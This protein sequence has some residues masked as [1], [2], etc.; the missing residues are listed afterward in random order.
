MGETSKAGVER[1]RVGFEDIGCAAGQLPR[2]LEASIMMV[3]RGHQ[4]PETTRPTFQM[5]KLRLRGQ[6]ACLWSHSK[7]VARTQVL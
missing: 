7:L 3:T 6:V 2:A 1:T 4:H 5:G